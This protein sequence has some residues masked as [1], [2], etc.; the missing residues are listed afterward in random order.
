MN[1]HFSKVDIYEA[2]KLMKQC[3]SSLIIGER[4][5]ETTMRYHLMPFRMASIKKSVDYRCW[6]GYG[7]I[8]IL[9]HCWWECK[10]V[11]PFWNTVWYFLKNLETEIPFDQQSH[12]WVYTQRIIN[13]SSINTHAHLCSLWTCLQ[14]QRPGTNPNTHRQ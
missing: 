5:I 6:R 9:L 7:E 12:Y 8:G 3:A 1:R 13:R 2:N 14:Q 4:Q 10:L 11:Q